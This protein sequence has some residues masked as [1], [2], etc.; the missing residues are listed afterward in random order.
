MKLVIGLGNP[1]KEYLKTWHNIGFLALDN[2]AD[3]FNF[4]KFKADKKFKA[5]ITT[6]HIGDEKIILVKP[7]TFMNNSGSAVLTIAKYYKLNPEDIIVIHD[8]IDLPLGRLKIIKNSSAGGHNGIKSI[9]QYL[10]TQDFIRIKIGI[11]T[12]KKEKIGSANYVMTK[13][14]LLQSSKAKEV[15]KK[16]TS[17]IEE[18]TNVSLTSAMNKFN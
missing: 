13:I 15:I 6:G 12:P 1:G 8:D 9:I 16:V 18:V 7:L 5:E 11:T 10:K 4:E 2:I 3:V 17:A 14:G